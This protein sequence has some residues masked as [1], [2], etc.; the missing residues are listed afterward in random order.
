MSSAAH[1]PPPPPEP[2]SAR[3]IATVGLAGLISGLAIVG[4]YQVTLPRI[5]ENQAA[6]LRSAVFEVVPGA[7]SLSPLVETD[8]ALAPAGPG[9]AGPGGKPAGGGAEVFAAWT[10]SGEF[11]GYAVAAEGPG[12]QDTIK[13]LFGFDAERQRVVGMQVL[14]SRETPGLGD[15]IYKDA[16]FVAEFR[17]LAVTPEVMVVPKGT[18]AGPSAVDGIT[19]ATIS[20]KAVAKIVS[21]GAGR[22]KDRLPPKGYPAPAEGS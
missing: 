10:E 19:G 20:S 4:S 2:G 22:W 14:E 6:A 18:E 21:A 8:G 5:L 13:L 11:A 17:D 12:F 15:K 1:G 9:A 7:A 3:L 16:A